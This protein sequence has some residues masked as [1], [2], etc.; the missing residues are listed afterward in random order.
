LQTAGA[1]SSK[2]YNFFTFGVN[3]SQLIYDFG[4]TPGRIGAATASRD[5][6]L[7]SGD[8][9]TTLAVLAVRRAYF[10]ARAQRDLADVAAEAVGNQEKH[11]NQILAFVRAGIRPEIDL[12][13]AKTALANARVQLVAATNNYDVSVAQLNQAMGLP[14]DV[15]HIL[16]DSE[17]PPVADEEGA[18]E[19]LLAAALRARPELA[20]ADRQRLAEERTVSALR[21]GYGPA[22]SAIANAT[23]IGT[24]IDNLMPNWYVG[25]SLTWPLLQGGLTR[26]QVREARGTPTRAR[27]GRRG[28]RRKTE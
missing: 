26:G 1:T 3:A 6:T 5:G 4:Q 20:A 23:D 17:L 14:A 15:P 24:A 11:V 22:L 12:A 27:N 16:T 19:A 9:T 7:A 13:Q 21:G 18:P 28:R 10:Q 2:T 8:A 25:L